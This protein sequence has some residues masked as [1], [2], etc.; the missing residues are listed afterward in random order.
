[1][2]ETVLLLCT[3]NYASKQRICKTLSVP[4]EGTNPFASTPPLS[5]QQAIV[6]E[7]ERR[8]SVADKVEK[9][10][11]AELKRAEQ[12]RQSILKKAFSGG[13]VPQDPS[14]DPASVLLERIRVEKS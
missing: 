9:T 1:M 3:S 6:S 11:T 13:L 14:D 7:I 10:V 2:S 5:E 4:R 12:L 8:L